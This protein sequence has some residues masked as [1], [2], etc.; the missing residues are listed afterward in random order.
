MYR[1][2]TKEMFGDKAKET[3][4]NIEKVTSL[5]SSTVADSKTRVL[6]CDASI[7]DAAV[8]ANM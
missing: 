7:L 6:N 4:Y 1:T 3:V 2:E 8:I 5:S